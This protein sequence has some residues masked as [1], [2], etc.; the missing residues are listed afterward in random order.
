MTQLQLRNLNRF[1]HREL[2]GLSVG[3]DHPQYARRNNSAISGGLTVTGGIQSDCPVVITG[4]C[5]NALQVSDGGSNQEFKVDTVSN[6]VQ[7]GR[8]ALTGQLIVGADNGGGAYAGYSTMINHLGDLAVLEAATSAH[9]LYIPG[10]T[11]QVIFGDLSVYPTKPSILS[12][13]WHTVFRSTVAF[14]GGFAWRLDTTNTTANIQPEMTAVYYNGAGGDVLNLPVTSAVLSGGGSK[15]GGVI[16]IKDAVTPTGLLE[17]NKCTI[18]PQPGDLIDGSA[19]P[20]DLHS[21]YGYVLQTD[22]T[23]WFSFI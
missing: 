4:N 7:V 13:P 15:T 2:R 3:D 17:G 21:G 6:F 12:T 11:S 19:A 16:L 8:S 9:S 20:L 18:V 22:G 23:N 10:S 14:R 5:S 1:Y